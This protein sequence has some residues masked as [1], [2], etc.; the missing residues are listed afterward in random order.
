MK[1]GLKSF[2]PTQVASFRLII[3]GLALLPFVFKFLKQVQARDWLPL[4]VVAFFGNG[5]PYFLFPLAQT[6]LGSGITGMLNSLVPLFTLLI[7]VFIFKNELK[8]IKLYGVLLGLV[9][10][11]VLIL[12][13]HNDTQG[14]Y[15]Y[16]VL[17]II[18]TIC[19]A[20]SVNTLKARL[21]KFNPLATA[22]IP[23]AIVMVP[24]LIY[25]PL[26]DP[27]DFTA[28]TPVQTRSFV[29]VITLALVGTAAAMIIFNR[30]IQLSSAVFASSVTYLIPV[31]AMAWGI[32][33]NENIG[34]LH[35]IGLA[36][37]LVAVYLINKKER[38]LHL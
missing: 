23:I 19:Y 24:V 21:S 27:V 10:A 7:S 35:F 2:T 28:F 26:F 20:I 17:V 22:A 15:G 38:K 31:V 3:S 18:A 30:L 11:I 29:A 8:R 16:G 37:V 25:I 36:I 9:G 1:E 32:N 6:Q 5:I 34:L 13:T 14:Q 12:A 4:F 33:D